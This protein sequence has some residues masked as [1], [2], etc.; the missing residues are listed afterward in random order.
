M[1]LFFWNSLSPSPVEGGLL[2]SPTLIASF[3]ITSLKDNAPRFKF[4]VLSNM[5]AVRVT[6]YHRWCI[7]NDSLQH[8]PIPTHTQSPAI[9]NKTMSRP[10]VLCWQVP[11]NRP[12]AWWRFADQFHHHASLLCSFLTLFPHFMLVFFSIPVLLET[13]AFWMWGLV[14]KLISKTSS[15]IRPINTSSTDWTG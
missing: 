8:H 14:V 10:V 5:C 15:C 6:A 3:N 1:H 4:L 9:K 7:Q 11:R 2:I 13:F 12:Y